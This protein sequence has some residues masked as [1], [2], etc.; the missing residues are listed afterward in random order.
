MQQTNPKQASQ[1]D[2]F[3]TALGIEIRHVSFDTAQADLEIQP[4]YCNVLG[5][6][7]GGGIFTLADASFAA[8]C[9][10]GDAH[11]IKLVSRMN[12]A[13]KWHILPVRSIGLGKKPTFKHSPDINIGRI[14]Y[15]DFIR[16]FCKFPAAL[17]RYAIF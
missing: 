3:A 11:F 16:I 13:I 17:F 2:P 4:H 10:S 9:N 14:E 6:V 5:T 12:L 15:I 8:V 1:Q 7:H